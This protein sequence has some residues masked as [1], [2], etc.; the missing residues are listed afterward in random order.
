MFMRGEIPVI[1]VKDDGGPVGDGLANSVVG[2]VAAEALSISI[3]TL[4]PFRRS[5]CPLAIAGADSLAQDRD[6]PNH[7]EQV[8]MKALGFSQLARRRRS[9]HAE[10]FVQSG[11]V[12]RCNGGRRLCENRGRWQRERK[13]QEDW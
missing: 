3:P 8:Q 5:V 4:S 7:A 12:F 13:K 2:K 6:W 10:D 9:N 1:F 11:L